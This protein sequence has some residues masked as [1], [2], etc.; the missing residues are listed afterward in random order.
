MRVLRC[1]GIDR[2]LRREEKYPK[3]RGAALQHGPACL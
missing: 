2:G 3:K 1:I